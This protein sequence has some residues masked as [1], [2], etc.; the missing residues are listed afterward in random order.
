[1]DKGAL[2]VVGAIVLLFVLEPVLALLGA[3]IGAF[4]RGR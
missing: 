4:R 2:I 1:M 3:F